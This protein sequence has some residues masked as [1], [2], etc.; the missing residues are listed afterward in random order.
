MFF[1]GGFGV[2]FR[3][4]EQIEGSPQIFLFAVA[5]GF[6]H[7]LHRFIGLFFG[8]FPEYSRLITHCVALN[9]LI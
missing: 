3:S 6:V 9:L 2:V 4:F 8:S 1:G 5:H 7:R